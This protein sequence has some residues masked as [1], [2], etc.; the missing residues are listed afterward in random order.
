MSI[1]LAHSPSR[2]ASKNKERSSS[3]E[4]SGFEQ[5][6]NTRRHHGATL[7]RG[8][9]STPSLIKGMYLLDTCTYIW[10]VSDPK[11]LSPE[12]QKRI[13]FDHQGLLISSILGFEIGILVKKKRIILPQKTE[14]WLNHT[15]EFF[16]IKEIPMTSKIALLSTQLPKIHDD[17]VDRIIIATAIENNLTILTPDQHI[18]AYKKRVKVLW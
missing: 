17:P 11:K 18:K 4:A 16:G 9:A 14:E 5:S 2:S 13:Q 15:Q 12:V 7:K 10:L 8:L 3:P 1:W 6:K